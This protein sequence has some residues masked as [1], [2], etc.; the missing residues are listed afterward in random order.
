[1]PSA[2]GLNVT[3]ENL[4]A[5]LVVVTLHTSVIGQPYAAA[6][7]DFRFQIPDSIFEISDLKALHVHTSVSVYLTVVQSH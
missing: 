6:I 5:R 2:N 7:P 1:V 4:L 3:S